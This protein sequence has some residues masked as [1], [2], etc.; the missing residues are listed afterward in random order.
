M[1]RQKR[2]GAVSRELTRHTFVH[3]VKEHTSRKRINV[4]VVG[5]GLIYEVCP[6]V[7]FI[8]LFLYPQELAGDSIHYLTN[9][10]S[11]FLIGCRRTH[12]R[13]VHRS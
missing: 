5:C 4:Q 1:R 6:E 9:D 7:G 2:D 11:V 12:A 10:M 8:Y 3:N 13:R